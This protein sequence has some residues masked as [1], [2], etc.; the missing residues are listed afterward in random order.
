[1]IVSSTWALLHRLKILDDLSLYFSDSL[2]DPNPILGV[3]KFD[4]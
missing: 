4:K 2:T 3:I 1:M